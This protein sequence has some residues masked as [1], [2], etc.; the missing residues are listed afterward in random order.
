[1]VKVGLTTLKT[2]NLTAICGMILK[3]MRR[4]RHL[5]T[6]WATKFVAVKTGPGF[7]STPDAL[8]N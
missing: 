8:R 1:M 2:E 6:L 7:D 5:I 4:P 3:K